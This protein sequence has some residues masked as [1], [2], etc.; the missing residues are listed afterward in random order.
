V[1]RVTDARPIDSRVA[2]ASVAWADRLIAV[3]HDIAAHPELNFE[4]R[5]AHEVLVSLLDDAGLK[6]EPH[7]HGLDTAFV[8]RA[9]SGNGP[10]VAILC[11]YDALP[12]VGHACGHNVIAAVG[13]GAG[14][15]AAHVVDE[16]DG[17]LVVVGTP[18]EEGGGGKVDLLEAGAFA[19]VDVALMVHPADADLTHMDTIAVA[20]YRA[21]YTGRAAHAAAAPEQGRNALDAAVLGYVNVAAL[22][23]HIG[24]RE[25]VHGIFT[26]GGDAANVVPAAAETVWFVRSPTLHSLG[27]LSERVHTCLQAGAD[28]AG[29]TVSI[30]REH[31]RY[32]EMLDNPVLVERYVQLAA[33]TG[34]EVRA[35]QGSR[36]VVGSTDM[37]NVSQV[38]PSIHP[39]IQVA[40]P[41]VAIHTADFAAAAV[42]GAADRAVIDG[43]TILARLAAACWAEAGLVAAARR[44][45]DAANPSRH[46]AAI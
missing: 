28:A 26:R 20:Q 37:G 27:L 8:A 18:A 15:I 32:A 31:H 35:P 1:A 10:T 30:T 24:D 42:S 3:A 6:V 41:G 33:A 23:Q 14:I 12:G 19:D 11:E 25:R 2:D 44:A 45:F 16:L 46:H 39:M 9:G 40:P 22:R 21:T 17:R 29:C 7:A 38:V 43:A 34:R 36:R 13:A 5:H 4:E